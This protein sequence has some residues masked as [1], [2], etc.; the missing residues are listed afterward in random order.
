MLNSL[1]TG[2]TLALGAEKEPHQNNDELMCWGDT[3]GRNEAPEIS[4]N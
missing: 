3:C 4:E 1:G 2:T